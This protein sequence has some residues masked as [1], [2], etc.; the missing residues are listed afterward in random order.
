MTETT[1]E[2]V[3]F[4]SLGIPMVSCIIAF[5]SIVVL[6]FSSSSTLNFAMLTTST[7]KGGLFEMMKGVICLLI[8]AAG[9][10]GPIGLLAIVYLVEYAP[11][12]KITRVINQAINNLVGVPSIFIGLFG[13]ALFT[14][15]L[16][17]GA[18][19]SS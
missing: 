7:L 6:L 2:R 11:S 1:K 12:G 8:G 13:F 5:F 10:A 4:F 9:I 3:V 17:L 15:Q 18:L 19:T 16:G 14:T